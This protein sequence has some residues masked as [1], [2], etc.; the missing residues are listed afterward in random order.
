MDSLYN[1]ITDPNTIVTFVCVIFTL[2]VTWSNL[3]WKI[4]ELEKRLDKLDELDLDSRLT[5][6]EANLERIRGAIEELK[7]VK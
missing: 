5:R 3:N 7:K 1:Y 4:K 6:M 2:W